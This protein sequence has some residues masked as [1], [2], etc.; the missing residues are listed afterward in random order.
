MLI[1]FMLTYVMLRV[2]NH[3]QSRA[4]FQRA[5]SQTQSFTEAPSV[6]DRA[7]R[8]ANTVFSDRGLVKHRGSERRAQRGLAHI[9]YTHVPERNVLKE[10]RR[11]SLP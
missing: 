1:W 9:G 6:R 11:G 3:W 10:T 8:P 5:P 7:G 4:Q 2:L